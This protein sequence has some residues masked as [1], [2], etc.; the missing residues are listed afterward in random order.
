MLFKFEMYSVPKLRSH[1][2]C[3]EEMLSVLH[4]PRLEEVP[5]G[6]N[7]RKCLVCVTSEIR[8]QGSR[9]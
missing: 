7:L 9:S 4:N 8:W 5:V 6:V 2:L 1:V 3:I